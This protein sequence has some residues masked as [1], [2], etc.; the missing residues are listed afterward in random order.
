MWGGFGLSP[1]KTKLIL[2]LGNCEVTE[3]HV[4]DLT[5]IAAPLELVISRE[6]RSLHDVLPVGEQ[7][8]IT[9][10]R[11][12]DGTHLPNNQVS[13]VEA[14]NVA[15][16]AAWRTV[17]EHS[18]TIKLDGV[19]VTREYLFA[20]VRAETTPRVWVMPLA[21]LGTE[22]QAEGVEPAFPEGRYTAA[23]VGRPLDS[24]D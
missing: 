22:A 13:I 12:A 10:N 4:L 9:H 17:F 7:Y 3:T 2:E 5:V 1:D 15:D 19:G 6:E 21:G 8:I 24:P 16:R 14:E 23:P 20:A 11:A 18:N